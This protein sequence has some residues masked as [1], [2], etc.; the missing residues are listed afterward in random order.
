M[1]GR[2]VMASFDEEVNIDIS[3]DLSTSLDV[4]FREAPPSKNQIV[5]SGNSS[6]YA[7]YVGD[8]DSLASRVSTYWYT[9]DV[10]KTSDVSVSDKKKKRDDVA[11]DN[12]YA[13]YEQTTDNGQPRLRVSCTDTSRPWTHVHTGIVWTP[14]ASGKCVWVC[15]A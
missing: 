3:T 2:S 5:V 4:V 9:R 6:K 11:L 15:V 12:N 14:Q 8:E 1:Q 7:R 10:A 13:I